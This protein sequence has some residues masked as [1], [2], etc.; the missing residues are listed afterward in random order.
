M[1]WYGI[2]IVSI[3]FLVGMA[4]AAT[5]VVTHPYLSLSQLLLNNLNVAAVR[6]YQWRTVCTG[7]R[8]CVQWYARAPRNCYFCGRIAMDTL[9]SR[10]REI[11]D[12]RE[13][14]QLERNNYLC[15]RNYERQGVDSEKRICTRWQRSCYPVCMQH[16]P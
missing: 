7:P 4:F 6:C 3:Y 9:V 2:F 11:C 10:Y 13:K 15:Y 16:G 5:N 8:R 12:E 14:E 1:K